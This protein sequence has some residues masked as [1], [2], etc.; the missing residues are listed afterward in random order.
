MFCSWIL[1]P[2]PAKLKVVIHWFSVIFFGEQ[3]GETEALKVQ[4]YSS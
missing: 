3:K 2:I 4:M 1:F